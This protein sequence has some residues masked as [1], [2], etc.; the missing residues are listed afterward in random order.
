MT[1]PSATEQ[2]EKLRLFN[3]KAEII[4]RSRFVEQT[5]RPD[6]GFTWITP[7]DGSMETEWRG[8]DEDATNAL[9][10]NLRLFLRK[11]KRDG[12]NFEQIVKIYDNLPGCDTEKEAI[13]RVVESLDQILDAPAVVINSEHFTRHQFLDVFLYGGLAHLNDDKLG[14]YEKWMEVQASAWMQYEF[15]KTVKAIVYVICQIRHINERTI[16]TLNTLQIV[17]K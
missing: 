5:F 10:L 11:Q 2:M 17:G 8:A 7:G 1:F 13:R 14:R 4:R 6:H 12:I 9:V 3:K 15:E 16:A